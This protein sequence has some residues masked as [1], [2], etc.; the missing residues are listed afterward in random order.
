MLAVRC[1]VLKRAWGRGVK[2]QNL[3]TFLD[4]NIQIRSFQNKYDIFVGKK[5]G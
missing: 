4:I 5:F 3:N 1:Y 2:F